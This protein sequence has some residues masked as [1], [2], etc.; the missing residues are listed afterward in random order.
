M[1]K[2]LVIEDDRLT[3]E[4]ILELLDAE[5]FDA[6]GAE[7][8][9][10]GVELV[11]QNRPDLILC[12]VM[13]P[14]LDGYGV[15]ETLRSDPV[16]AAIPFIFLTAKADRPDVRAAMEE[17]ADDYLTKPC[18]PA[19][20]LRAIE[21]RLEKRTVLDRVTEEKLEQL[22][23]SIIYSLPHELRTP[24]NGILGFSEIIIR[25]C[26]RLSLS[27]IREMVRSIHRSGQRLHRM[28]QKFLLYAELDLIA[29]KPQEVQLL[30]THR[31]NSSKTIVTATGRKQ[32]IA[33]NRES[34]L[35]L[36]LQECT[37]HISEIMLHQLVEELIENAFK[38][39]TSGTP[40]RLASRSEGDRFILSI[41]D[42]GRGMTT[43]Q[44]DRVGAYMQFDRSLY[45]Q[46]GMGLG[47][48]LAKRI[49]E[50]HAGELRIESCLGQ[51][52]TVTVMLPA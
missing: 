51:Q 43:E 44:I 32:A 1:T 20:L 18:Q 16:T 7:N 41:A 37:A 8:G 9:K 36:D 2:I 39:S 11:R 46:Q 6:M 34:D 50:L 13:M 35:E 29:S 47:L 4:N 10:I 28:I 25:Q 42:W 15:L 38:F 21:T 52:T 23:S 12:D 48:I 19:E 31:I 14:E 30:R 24:L 49:V 27:E 22:R 17:G 5:E 3:R 26:D 45:E 33:A 40:V